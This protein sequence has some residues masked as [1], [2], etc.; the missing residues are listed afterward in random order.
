MNNKEKA[1]E[2]FKQGISLI[3][4]F[5]ITGLNSYEVWGALRELDY[6]YY[7][8]LKIVE[9]ERALFSGFDKLYSEGESHSKHI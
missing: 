4:I 3:E 7:K 5:E 8:A 6:D 9:R 1:V 2:L